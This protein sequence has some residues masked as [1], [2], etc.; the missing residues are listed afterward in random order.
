MPGEGLQ[1]RLD[2][3]GR[4]LEDLGQLLQRDRLL[5]HEED[6]LQDGPR[7]G[8]ERLHSLTRGPSEPPGITRTRI[9][10]S[11]SSWAISTRPQ[12]ASSRRARK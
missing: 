7:L 12:R 6:R 2:R 9:S 3:G 10:E 5:R 4:H 1:F 8:H 11:Q